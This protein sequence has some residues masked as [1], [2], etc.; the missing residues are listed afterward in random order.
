MRGK[1]NTVVPLT[2]DQVREYSYSVVGSI[3]ESF[4]SI[5][6][7][8]SAILAALI[9]TRT[10]PIP[11]ALRVIMSFV[12]LLLWGGSMHFVAIYQLFHIALSSTNTSLLARIQ[13]LSKNETRLNRLFLKWTENTVVSMQILGI[14]LDIVATI[15][16]STSLFVAC[17][18]VL[19]L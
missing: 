6:L 1:K 10:I 18:L 5:F 11:F 16:M 8:L 9:A 7:S 12:V 17:E 15:I 19:W 4:L 14:T 2:D 13:E 3:V